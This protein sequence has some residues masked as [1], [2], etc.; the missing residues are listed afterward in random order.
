MGTKTEDGNRVKVIETVSSPIE[1]ASPSV[2]D[3]VSEAQLK[4]LEE[5]VMLL[6]KLAEKRRAQLAYAI[7]ALCIFIVVQFFV[8]VGFSLPIFRNIKDDRCIVN[9]KD[10]RC[11]VNI[12]DDRC[13]LEIKDIRHRHERQQGRS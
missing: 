12:K 1:S 4:E 8:V 10:D 5:S 13:E 2:D 9:I 6:Q 11:I 3:E 7:L